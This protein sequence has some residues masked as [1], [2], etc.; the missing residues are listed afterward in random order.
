MTNIHLVNIEWK[1]C[2]IENCSF[3]AKQSSN[4][5][6]HKV[7]VHNIGVKM[8]A[9]D[10]DNCT[11]QAKQKSYIER[12]K[13]NVHNINVIW[14]QCDVVNCKFKSK[15]SSNLKKHKSNIHNI[16]ST[17]FKC[18]IDQ[19][20]YQCKTSGGLQRHKANIHN[21][22]VKWH[23]CEIEKC[24]FKFK[25]KSDLT[26]HKA[27]VHNINTK[28][29]KCDFPSCSIQTKRNADL[30]KHKKMVHD[31]GKLDCEC[32]YKKCATLTS[33]VFDE[34]TM[35]SCRE[36][37]YKIT[38]YKCSSEKIVSEWL[39]INYKYPIIRANQKVNGE[40]CL[41]YRPDIMYASEN[42]VIYVEIDEHQHNKNNEYSCDE[43]RMSELYDETPGKLVVFIRF[44]PDSYATST[45][46]DNHIP[47]EERLQILLLTLNYISDNHKN[48]TDKNYIHCFYLFYS[49]NNAI[50]S[51]NLPVHMIYSHDDLI[52]SIETYENNVKI[53]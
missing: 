25:E 40:V 52:C 34:S 10:V 51:K 26:Q 17:I 21:I 18:G 30:N 38:G 33:C 19:C 6:L 27:A 32:C 45:H 24:D 36:C 5:T 43:R 50:I 11:Y 42:L 48:L 31:I 9:C 39:K 46:E 28:W 12:H 20:E 3:K 8:F 47:L 44:N 4:I 16:N 49:P 41:K 23:C 22:N 37:Y 2:D 7:N 13:M 14:Y 35:Q 1:Y 15:S 53:M 29:F